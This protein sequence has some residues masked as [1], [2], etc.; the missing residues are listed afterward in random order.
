MAAKPLESLRI[1]GEKA[2]FFQCCSCDARSKRFRQGKVKLGIHASAPATVA[3]HPP[4]PHPSVAGCSRRLRIAGS[5][6]SARNDQVNRV[7]QPI[8]SSPFKLHSSPFQLH[9]RRFASTGILSPT[10][11]NRRPSMDRRAYGVLCARSA[12]WRASGPR[13][14]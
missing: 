12:D 4:F 11:V 10:G 14:R 6:R 1:V 5:L 2:G 13:L 3:A 9:S 8:G 7:G